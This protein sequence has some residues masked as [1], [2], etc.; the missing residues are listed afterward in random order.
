MSPFYPPIFTAHIEF[1]NCT[2][3]LI[4]P[5]IACILNSTTA[6]KSKAALWLVVLN[7]TNEIVVMLIYELVDVRVVATWKKLL[8]SGIA[9]SVKNVI[10]YF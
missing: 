3:R 5:V 2:H 7:D 10:F 4:L 6:S 1:C 9:A 8:M